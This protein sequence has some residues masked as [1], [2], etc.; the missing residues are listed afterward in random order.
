M[1]QPS[2]PLKLLAEREKL[3]AIREAAML[4]KIGQLAAS[5]ATSGVALGERIASD[6]SAFDAWRRDHLDGVDC[7]MFSLIDQRTPSARPRR[8]ECRPLFD[9]LFIAWA[10]TAGVS[11][12][13]AESAAR[14]KRNADV[15]LEATQQASM[16]PRF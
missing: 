6:F 11:L 13:E 5:S 3:P 8:G 15:E 12:Q 9:V 10:R 14:A 16:A 7:D 1:R 2:L 4:E